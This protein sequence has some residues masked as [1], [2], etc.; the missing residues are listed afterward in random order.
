MGY[1]LYSPHKGHHYNHQ[2]LYNLLLE[3]F[4]L[5]YND[6]FETKAEIAVIRHWGDVVGMTAAHDND[7]VTVLHV[8]CSTWNLWAYALISSLLEGILVGV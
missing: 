7:V 8:C 3:Y 4:D 6:D 5:Q 2:E 1:Y